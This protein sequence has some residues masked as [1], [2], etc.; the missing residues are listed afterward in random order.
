MAAFSSAALRINRFAKYFACSI[1]QALA[2]HQH[3]AL[4]MPL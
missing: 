2:Q 3:P 4:C 1:R